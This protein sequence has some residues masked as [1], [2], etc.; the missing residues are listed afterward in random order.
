[1][2]TAFAVY[3][4]ACQTS[5]AMICIKFIRT[6]TRKR[7]LRMLDRANLCTNI[8]AFELKVTCSAALP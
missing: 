5:K 2:Y 6:T 8:S 7:G 3:H 4:N 1:M